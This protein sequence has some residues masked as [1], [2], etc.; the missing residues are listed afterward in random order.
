MEEKTRVMKAQPAGPEKESW[1]MFRLKEEQETPARYEEAAKFLATMISISLT[2]FLSVSGISGGISP[3]GAAKGVTVILIIWLVSLFCSFLV[4]FPFPYKFADASI[5]T[6]KDAHKK[7]VKNKR[8]LLKLSVGLYFIAL[9][10]LAAIYVFSSFPTP[11]AEPTPAAPAVSTA[12]ASPPPQP[13]ADIEEPGIPEGLA[14]LAGTWRGE[15]EDGAYTYTETWSLSERGLKGGAVMDD[16]EGKRVLTETLEIHSTGAH[17]LYIATIN[18][19]NPVSFTL[20]NVNKQGGQF[21]WTFENKEHD[22]PQRIIY[23]LESKDSIY[24][25]AEGTEK[26]ELKKEE[27]RL[28]R[29]N[30]GGDQ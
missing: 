14:Q 25:R 1:Y 20:V 6:F 5:D 10:L 30:A 15:I 2:I 23:R 9:F 16:K 28:A 17:V 11:P 7:I 19:G 22:F 26:G 18:K 21:E 27:F 13:S 29:V 12:Q 3:G 4:L 24:A 8:T